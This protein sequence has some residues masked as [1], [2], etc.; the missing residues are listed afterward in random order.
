[1]TKLSYIREEALVDYPWAI[2][3]LQTCATRH[4]S[5]R[6][7]AEVI[8]NHDTPPLIQFNDR[9][10]CREHILRRVVHVPSMIDDLMKFGLDELLTFAN[11]HL[12][13]DGESDSGPA[14]YGNNP[15]SDHLPD[16]SHIF[17]TY[18]ETIGR[19][20]TQ[21]ASKFYI[22]P[23]HETW[24]TALR[25][26]EHRT[27]SFY[28]AFQEVDLITPS[29]S[30][31]PFEYDMEPGVLES[32]EESV[33]ERLR[34]YGEADISLAI[35]QFLSETDASHSTIV[36]S[37]SSDSNFQWTTSKT[38]NGPEIPPRTQY[39]PSDTPGSF[40]SQY[41]AQ[42]RKPKHAKTSQKHKRVREGAIQKVRLP[43]PPGTRNSSRRSLVQPHFLQRAWSRAVEHDA[44]FILL[45]C[46]TT[47]RIGI[48]DRASNTL[49]LSDVIDPHSP[50]YGSIHIGLHAAIVSEALNKPPPFR[51]TSHYA[52]SVIAPPAHRISSET[53]PEAHEEI[54][55]RTRPDEFN[56]EISKLNILLVS[57]SFACYQSEAPS[58]FLREASSCHPASSGLS[59]VKPK[60]N[61]SYP[62]NECIHFVA[63]RDV[64]TSMKVAVY[65]GYATVQ[66]SS[67]EMCQPAIL[68]IAKHAEAYKR[69]L[70]EYEVYKILSSSGVT[71]GILMVHG[72]FQ[73][74]ETG[75]CGLLMQDGGT[76]LFEREQIRL[77]ISY[78]KKFRITTA[79][80]EKLKAIV[81]GINNASAARILHNDPKP[82]NICFNA[83]GDWF[84]ID[85]DMARIVRDPREGISEDMETIEELRDGTF[86]LSTY[87]H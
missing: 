47:E 59:F 80:F 57:L 51:E 60:P 44:T 85:F 63:H 67:G 23:H 61:K 43:A 70:H 71:N 35:L 49:F 8:Q 15:F 20:A 19:A 26:H 40:W 77:G 16:A 36:N 74:I 41:H 11:A 69:L 76:T 65:R 55:M 2:R 64:G 31:K 62:Q 10:M 73:D 84:L 14:Y 50:G 13:G 53:Q 3:H 24:M 87:C 54:Q 29:L 52:R 27:L 34:L 82:D 86:D 25:F 48:R 56:Q 4:H 32:V 58:A 66:T 18:K 45:H 72:M 83:E 6:P 28:P 7:P 22:H 78:P 21:Y 17:D 38:R 33:K 30:Y 12:T 9:H 39:I 75:M 81:Q 46:G 68:K 79:E 1:M 42:Q 5:D 37:L